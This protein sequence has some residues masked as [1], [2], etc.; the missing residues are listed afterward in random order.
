[1]KSA[2]WSVSRISNNIFQVHDNIR[3]GK[4]NFERRSCSCRRWQQTGIPYGHVVVALTYQNFDDCSV[5]AECY[6]RAD[7]HR[8]MYHE[9]IHPL[10]H[11]SE[12]EVT[13]DLLTV[14]VPITLGLDCCLLYNI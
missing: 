2:T 14:R 13:D 1:M 8:Q 12:W 6:F 7:T 3:G 11:P 10:P 4:V 5:Y 9:L